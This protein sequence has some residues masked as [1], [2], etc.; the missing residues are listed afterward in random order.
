MDKGVVYLVGAGPGDPKLITIR[1]LQAVERADVVVYD[2]LASP[3]LLKHM[4]PGAEKIF[5]GK[6]PDKHMLKQEEI[7][8]LLVDLALQ[9]K[10]VTRLKGGD[11]SVFGRVGEE[12]E[13]LAEHGIRFEIVPGITSAIA[14]PAYAGIPV[15]HRDFTSSFSIVTG[16]E[17]QNKTYSNVNWENLSQAS[18][19]LIFLMG[20]ANLE[21]ICNRLIDGGKLPTTPVALIRWG[22]WM[23]QETL[24]GTLINIVAKVKAANFQSPAVI[25]VGDVVRLREKLAWFEK[26]P[27]FGRRILVTRARSQASELVNQIED[28]GGEAVEFPVIRIQPPSKPDAKEALAAALRHLADYN[29]VLFTSVNGVEHFF[30]QLRHHRIDV[31]GLAGARVA[32]VG[33]KTSEAL[34]RY[35]IFAEALPAKFQGDE[36]LA[37]IQ[38]ELKPGQRALLPTADIAKEYLPAKLRQM[39]LE[40]TEVD[41]YE[42][43]LETSGGADVIELLRQRAIHIITFTSSSTVTN[44]LRALT[45]LGADDAL[46]LLKPCQIACIGPMTA[47]TATDAGLS[48]DFMPDEATVNALVKSLYIK[49]SNDRF[50]NI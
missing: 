7:N 5:V 39:G 36:L 45:E 2:R 48:V 43:V 11:P 28:L 6:L 16:H 1:G 30:H 32:A 9:G 12:A 4:K 50:Y 37:A 46:D 33:P 49:H 47:R 18:G 25:I 31:R 26:K 40:V 20:V 13:L 24:T 22:T 3:R 23:E 8:Q 44:L 27:L 17:Y 15:T 21:F 41:V 42:T 10:T 34:E 29:W 38:A 19:T 14:V 35:G